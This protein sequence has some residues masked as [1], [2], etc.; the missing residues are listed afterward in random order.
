MTRRFLWGYWQLSW[1]LEQPD[2]GQKKHLY[3]QL[4]PGSQQEPKRRGERK[5][6]EE[7]Q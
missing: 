4:Y 1:H 7:R 3:Q 2:A 6:Q 5:M